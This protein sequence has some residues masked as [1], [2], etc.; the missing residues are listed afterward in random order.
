MKPWIIDAANILT[1][2]AQLDDLGIV[3]TN[4]IK[5]FL[6]DDEINFVVAPKGF[7]KTLLLIA[8]RLQYHREQRSGYTL[9]PGQGLLVDIPK[10]GAANLNIGKGSLLFLQDRRT[11]EGLWRVCLS[12]SI[13]KALRRDGNLDSV[14]SIRNVLGKHQDSGVPFFPLL[15]KLFGEPRLSTPLDYLHAILQTFQKKMLHE[16]LK[17]QSAMDDAIAQLHTPVAIFIDNVDEYFEEHL[18]KADTDYRPSIRGV[19]DTSLWYLSQHGLIFA[20][21]TMCRTNHHIRIFASIRKEAYQML[22]GT[23]VENVRGHCIEGFTYSKMKLIEILNNNVQRTDDSLLCHPAQKNDDAAYALCGLKTISHVKSG[24]EEPI[25]SY[26]YRHTLKRPR[27]VI[28]IGR[29]LVYQDHAERTQGGVRA[30]VNHAATEI[31]RDYV[32]IVVPH[33]NFEDEAAFHS[34]LRLIPHNILTGIALR[35][36]CGLQ[37][38]GACTQ[39]S[40]KECGFSNPFSELYRLGLLGTVKFDR[41]VGKLQQFFPGPGE[42][43][44]EGDGFLPCQ[45]AAELKYYLLH[46]ILNE[47]LGGDQ[48]TRINQS[49]SVGDGRPWHL[50]LLPNS[51]QRYCIFLSY[52]HDDLNFVMRLA[53]ELK[54]RGITHW[55]DR[56]RIMA[57]DSLFNR[58]ARGI[59][60]CKY[61]GVVISSN[62]IKSGW[63]EQEMKLAMEHEIL[64]GQIKVIPILINDV[65]SDA[66]ESIKDKSFADFRGN[67]KE[68]MNHLV[69]RLDL[70]LQTD[71]GKKH[72]NTDFTN[73]DIPFI[74]GEIGGNEI[75]RY[76]D[77]DIL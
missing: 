45:E 75:A 15:Y 60:Q 3:T 42:L 7:G 37:N 50:P 65:W 40:C 43:M 56:E 71:N 47:L 64:S 46:P 27:D 49:I 35:R 70:S 73:E 31:A 61:L 58:I 44:R 8:K 11:W 34:F 48:T 51:I 19:F 62:A 22:D 76:S 38:G 77:G 55:F 72:T 21:K 6:I 1:K 30:A 29:E 28:R 36:I 68:G 59:A 63:V 20:V 26:I 24:E 9:I 14:G 18:E 13:A 17:E 4:K 53:T 25:D 10:G 33:T 66:P 52:S 23:T 16:L 39:L 57:G 74:Y 12:L 5:M 41:S 54:S 32:K 69:M 67:F 2:K